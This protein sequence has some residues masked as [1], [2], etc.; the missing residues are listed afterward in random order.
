VAAFPTGC[1]RCWAT[2][3]AHVTVVVILAPGGHGG[4]AWPWLPA[5]GDAGG[6]QGAGTAARGCSGLAIPL[7][8]WQAVVAAVLCSWRNQTMH[9]VPFF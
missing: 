8:S 5:A 7:D 4:G 9:W 2:P 6:R 3:Q 1:T